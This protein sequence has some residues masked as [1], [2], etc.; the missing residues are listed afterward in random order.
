MEMFDIVILVFLLIGFLWGWSKGFLAQLFSLVG[1]I[2]G[3]LVACS[4]Y[5]SLGDLLAPQLGT[6]PTLGHIIA[7]FLIWILV[8]VFCTYLGKFLNKI[9]EAIKLG[10]VNSLLGG[11]FSA[12]KILLFMSVV[13][14]FL[15]FIDKYKQEPIV[16]LATKESSVLY[17]PVQEFAGK[18]LPSD[19]LERNTTDPEADYTQKV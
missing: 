16:D 11:I 8:P 10:W 3:F 13:L 12:F 1:A 6:S 9:M 15:E 7:F 4:L 14:T 19:F 5:G 17:Y 2:I 18:L